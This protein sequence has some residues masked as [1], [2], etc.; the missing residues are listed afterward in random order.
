MPIPRPL[1]GRVVLL[2][3]AGGD[4][5]RAM[6]AAFAFAGAKLAAAD[7]DAERAERAAAIAR[8][9]GGEAIA[10][11]LD[12]TRSDSCAEAVAAAV[13]VFGALS[14]LV[15]NAA[16][17]TVRGTVVDL[18]EEEWHRQ[19]AVNLTGPFLMSKHAIP[20][21]R[22]TGGGVVVNIASQLGHVGQEG[23]A[24]YAAAKAAI[25]NL[26]RVMA[27]DHAKDNIRVVSLSPGAIEGARVRSRFPDDAAMHAYN[28]RRHVLGR[29][30]RPDEIASA[31]VFLAS[32]AASFVTGADLLVDGGYTAW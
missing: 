27:I 11:A 18:P 22:D 2:T 21:I 25:H 14:V 10:L 7:I 3:G 23:L 8:E 4:I 5:G 16:A 29:M 17:F 28:D 19:M 9:A 32:D 20:A 12:V 6:A 13:R 26:T 24:A 31:A 1:D 15:N 30:G